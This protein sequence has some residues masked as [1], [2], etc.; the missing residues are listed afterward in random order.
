[1]AH[2]PGGCEPPGGYASED[3]LQG[4]YHDQELF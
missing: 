4:F 1:M 2:P 3:M